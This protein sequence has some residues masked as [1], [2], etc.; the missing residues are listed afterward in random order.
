MAPNGDVKATSRFDP[1]FTAQVI[2]ATGPKANPRLKQLISG[3]VQHLHDFLRE[4]EV[5]L[6]EYFAAIDMVCE[7][8][9]LS[10][11]TTI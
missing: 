9:I 10:L 2:N 11:A 5:T 1:K 6:D 4:N 7:L 3:L 8:L